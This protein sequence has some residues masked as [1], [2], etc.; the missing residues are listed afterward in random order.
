MTTR[1]PGLSRSSHRSRLQTANRLQA[2]EYAMRRFLVA[3]AVAALVLPAHAADVER[4]P[5]ASVASTTVT[6][7]PHW[8]ICEWVPTPSSWLR[9]R[10]Q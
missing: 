6:H 7:S 5:A 9:L 4:S 2:R 10:G 8:P 3:I 1:I